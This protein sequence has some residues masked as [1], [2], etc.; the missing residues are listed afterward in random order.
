MEGETKG[1]GRL[2]FKRAGL[3]SGQERRGA[4][5]TEGDK[6]EGGGRGRD[7]GGWGCGLYIVYKHPQ[8]RQEA[9]QPLG[10]PTHLPEGLAA[11][12]FLRDSA[13]SERLVPHGVQCVANRLGFQFVCL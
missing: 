11:H 2:E 1:G 6:G 8:T 5:R 10:A 12:V 4:A 9:G 13:V 7:R 3:L